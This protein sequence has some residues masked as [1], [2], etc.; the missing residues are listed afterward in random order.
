MAK[1][2]LEYSVCDM[3]YMAVGGQVTLHMKRKHAVHGVGASDEEKT[4]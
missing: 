3:G 4:K 2:S 1:E